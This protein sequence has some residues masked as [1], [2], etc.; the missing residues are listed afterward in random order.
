MPAE[1][2]E[3]LCVR[4]KVLVVD[5]DPAMVDLVD[6]VLQ[7]LRVPIVWTAPDGDKAWSIFQ[8]A[9]DQLDLIICDWVMPGMSGLDLL[10]RVRKSE[11]V[12]PFLM[13]TARTTAEAV[14]EARD[15]GVDAYIVKPFDPRALRDKI[16]TLI[17]PPPIAQT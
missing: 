8:K 7:S 2:F 16:V 1:D 12:V 15:A 3:T 6:A 9:G 13:L 11:S 17:T 5:D 14:A 4:L 10:R